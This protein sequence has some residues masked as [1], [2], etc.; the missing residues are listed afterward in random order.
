MYMCKLATHKNSC[1]L[2]ILLIMNVEIN[3]TS[4][5]SHSIERTVVAASRLFRESAINY[6]DNRYQPLSVA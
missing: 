6:E 2:I 3:I 5:P 4:G 1:T